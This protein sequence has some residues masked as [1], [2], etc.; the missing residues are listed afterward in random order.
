MTDCTWNEPGVDPYRGSIYA[1]VSRYEMPEDVRERLAA[2]AARFDF[3]FLLAIKKDS[4][5]GAGKQW[6][7]RD[8]HYGR[9]KVC[10][11]GVVRDKWTPD[12]LE[13]AMVYCEQTYC[14]AIPFV[15]RN[16]SLLL[17]MEPAALPVPVRPPLPQDTWRSPP[18]EGYG[19]PYTPNRTVNTVP[20]PGSW[21]LV[22]SALCALLWTTTKR[23]NQCRSRHGQGR[24]GA[25]LGP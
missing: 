24:A 6:E 4:V 13:R 10:R 17:P 1:A 19:V 15:C 22:L 16:V 5:T 2:R 3:D 11:G 9:R 12:M 21:V 20:E 18:G 23:R 8:M 25:S 14:I 7:L